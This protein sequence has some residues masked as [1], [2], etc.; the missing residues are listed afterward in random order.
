MSIK[1]LQ[2]NFSHRSHRRSSVLDKTLTVKDI[3]KYVGYGALFL[4][5]LFLVVIIPFMIG[6]ASMTCH[7]P[8]AE[9]ENKSAKVDAAT[10]LIDNIAEDVEDNSTD[11]EEEEPEEVPEEEPEPEEE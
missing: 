5:V 3:L 4:G 2:R 7:T 6:R 10:S 1:G 11:I 9:I 8:T